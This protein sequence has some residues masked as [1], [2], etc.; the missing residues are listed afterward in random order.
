MQAPSWVSRVLRYAYGFRVKAFDKDM[1]SNPCSPPSWGVRGWL[2]R[3]EHAGAFM[4][5]QG[6]RFWVCVY[7]EG[8]VYV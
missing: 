2:C 6:L 1:V 7:V 8:C 3:N 4:G 5:E